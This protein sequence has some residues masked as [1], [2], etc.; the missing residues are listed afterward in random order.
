MGAKPLSCPGCLQTQ[1]PCAQMN[2]TEE[3][4]AVSGG[5]ELPTWEW[6]KRIIPVLTHGQRGTSKI[7]EIGAFGHI[8]RR[9]STTW[10]AAQPLHRD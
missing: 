5:C 6:P 8:P 9:R 4:S 10:D 7:P 2:P 1:K 3:V